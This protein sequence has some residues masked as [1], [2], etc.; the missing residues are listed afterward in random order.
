[1]FHIAWLEF[2]PTLWR[3]YLLKLHLFWLACFLLSLLWILALPL[4]CFIFLPNFF[5]EILSEILLKNPSRL[6]PQNALYTLYGWLKEFSRLKMCD[7]PLWQLGQFDHI[8]IYL[9]KLFITFSLIILHQ[10]LQYWREGC[11]PVIPGVIL[12]FF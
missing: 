1:M 6:L 7:L 8:S 3:N 12:D 5:W 4:G 10:F 11:K 2:L 9:S